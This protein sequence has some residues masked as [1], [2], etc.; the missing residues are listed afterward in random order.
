MAIEHA[1]VRLQAWRGYNTLDWGGPTDSDGR[2]EWDSAP[3]DELNIYVGKEGF[4]N[5]RDN[6]IIADGQEHVIK[7]RRQIT[8]TGLVTDAD[9]GKPIPAFKAIPAANGSGW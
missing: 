8:V 3:Q 7:L 4:F 1:D 9:T 2:I 5:S 6:M